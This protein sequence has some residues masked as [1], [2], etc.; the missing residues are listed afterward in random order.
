MIANLVH[1]RKAIDSKLNVSLCIEASACENIY[2]WGVGLYVLLS[3]YFIKA[4][5]SRWVNCLTVVYLYTVQYHMELMRHIELASISSSW[6]RNR[7]K[8]TNI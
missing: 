4:V 8:S 1:F 2:E 7:Y 5:M 3:I 6:K